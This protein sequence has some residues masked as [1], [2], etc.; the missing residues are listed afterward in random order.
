MALAIEAKRNVA[1]IGHSGCGKTSLVEAILFDTGANSRLGSVE[2]GTSVADCTPDEQKRGMTLTAKTLRAMWRD[3]RIT[4]LDTPGY[5]DFIGDVIS[6]LRAVDNAIVV[7][8]AA[9]GIQVGTERTWQVADE[10]GL[11]R[12]VFI[13]KMDKENADFASLCEKLQKKWGDHLVPVT[14]PIGKEADFKGVV[15]VV[16]EKAFVFPG[17]ETKDYSEEDIPEELKGAAEEARFNLVERVAE[18]DD[19]LL[20]KYLEEGELSEDEL[21]SALR[22]GIAEGK[23]VPVLC[24]V[25]D[26]NIGVQ[27]L[28]DWIVDFLASPADRGEVR[29]KKP[30]SDEEV[31]RKPEEGEPVA[32]FVFKVTAEEH[33][34]EVTYFRVFSGK[35][36]SGQDLLNSTK[37]STER[38]GQLLFV[39][40]KQREELEEASAGDIVAV[41]KLKNTSI[42]DT[43]CDAKSPI[44]FDGWL[45]YPESV[46]SV[47]L[48]VDDKKQ[49]EKL[50]YGLAQLTREDP[51]VKMHVDQEFGQT[52]V[53]GLGEMQLEVMID[54]LKS[55][56]GVDVEVEEA[57]IP[58]RETIRS[59]AKAQGKYKKQTGG[60]GQYG[61]V[62]L[63]IEPL[64]RGA[65]FEFVDKIVG[66]VV[67]SKY[68]PAVE[69]GVREAMQKGVL[70]GY[71]VVD[72]RVTLYDGSFHP[73][74][75]SDLAFQIAGSLAFKKCMAEASP[76]LLE[77]IMEV[78]VVVPEEC[79]GD[80]TSDLNGRRG[81][82]M[83]I[84][85]TGDYQVVRAQVPLAEMRRYSTDLKSMTQ[86]RGYYT[87]R[88]SH[89]EEVPD[90]IAQG[91]IEQAQAEQSKEA[92]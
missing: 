62:W 44:L 72:V 18:S 14:L 35:L 48:R 22:K 5:T 32:A 3:T 16:R 87:M 83:G 85:H 23:I 68:I 26:R 60:R 6:G 40:G 31:V 66:G 55:R 89:Y 20:E 76:V 42:G 39:H 9:A 63:E 11:P 1:L 79:L 54:K 17:G 73:V 38:I 59:K 21:K 25:A 70:A 43:L 10:Y 57:K 50:S 52:I 71:P 8:D 2:Q 91:I 81:R 30:G 34:G 47:A 37:G 65:D 15:D 13:T 33:V 46:F 64:P 80:I 58:Y 7:I 67:P 75:S 27:V 74:D 41:A 84:E 56:F 28:L 82:I 77:P 86:G 4:L 51:T 29:G 49:Q 45:N 24:G 19:A 61:D 92:A 12:L 88:F 36:T 69:K 90:R 53:A 78:E